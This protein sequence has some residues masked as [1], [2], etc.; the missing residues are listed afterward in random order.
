VP[1]GRFFNRPNMGVPWLLGRATAPEAR[2]RAIPRG[3]GRAQHPLS[4][5]QGATRRWCPQRDPFHTPRRHVT[6]AVFVGEERV[7][8]K[9]VYLLCVLFWGPLCGVSCDD[10]DTR[11]PTMDVP[12]DLSPDVSDNDT[13]DVS[14]AETSD[15]ETT[16]AS[17]VLQC[18]NPLDDDTLAMLTTGIETLVSMQAGQSRTFELGIVE[19]CYVFTT[20][21]ACAT[22]SVEP[23]AQGASIDPM[24][25]TLTLES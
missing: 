16:D 12:G 15:A 20:I 13:M 4:I 23:S 3:L 17:D 19:C 10:S 11:G 5:G 18:S 25:G 14:D 9:A 21:D 1:S 2:S 22:W 7:M 6:I 8:R 24:S